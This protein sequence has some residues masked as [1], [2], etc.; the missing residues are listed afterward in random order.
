MTESTVN[1]FNP[2]MRWVFFGV[3]WWGVFL[4]CDFIGAFFAL[5]RAGYVGHD[6]RVRAL[7]YRHVPVVW[8]P[9]LSMRCW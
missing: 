1:M 9:A 8:L 4:S 2:P 5:S 7:S 3:L 6:W